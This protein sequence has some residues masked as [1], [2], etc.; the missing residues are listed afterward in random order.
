MPMSAPRFRGDYDSLNQIAQIFTQQADACRQTLRA[1]KGAKEV[2]ASGDWIGQ[3]ANAYYQE[4]DSSVLPTLQRLTAALD[5][6]SQVTI[7][8]VS[9]VRQAEADAAAC[10]RLQGAAG[11]MAG[12]AGY[13][14]GA[15]AGASASASG[16]A[17]KPGLLDRALNGLGGALG[18]IGFGA[19]GAP[20]DFIGKKLG[21]GAIATDITRGFIEEGADMIGGIFHAV[22]HPIDTV[23]GIAFAVTHPGQLWD[24]FKKPYVEAWE[25]GHPGQAIGRGIM[26]VGSMFL[27][28]GEAEAAGKAGELAEVAGKAGELADAAEAARAARAASEAAEIDEALNATFRGGQNEGAFET[29]ARLKRGN[30]GERLATDALAADGHEIL[31]YKP[32]ILG[33]NQGGIDMVT[34]KDGVVYFVDNKALSRSGNVSSVS[35]LTTNFEANQAAAL[36]DLRTGIAN[37]GSA[38]ERAVLQSAVD[39]VEAGNFKKVVT[40][41]NMTRN[42]AILSGV[43]ESLADQGL[44]FIDVFQP[45]GAR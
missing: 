1:V 14:A 19:L 23:K 21:I 29:A 27:G 37:A 20:L 17:A 4:M 32:S 35:A 30:L 31:S 7:K 43:T 33:T 9:V 28:V 6:A 11:V 36:A 10:F 25:S 16:S 2:L 15:F 13:A 3:G 26:A 18:V 40:N 24:A 45:L 44:E 39:A 12:G 22:T 42:E 34:M 8:I 5:N 38:Q 41:A